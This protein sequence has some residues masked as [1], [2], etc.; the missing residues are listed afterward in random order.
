MGHPTGGYRR[1]PRPAA[2]AL[3][4]LAVAAIL[5]AGVGSGGARSPA[6]SVVT[7]PS[8]SCHGL[9][10]PAKLPQNLPAAPDPALLAILEV[11]RRPQVPADVPP[12]SRFPDPFL[13]G[14]EVGYERLL[15]TTARGD[16]YYLIPA[17]LVPPSPRAHC[18]PPRS[19][20]QQHLE[21]QLRLHPRFE[22]LISQIGRTASGGGGGGPSTAAA[23]TAGTATGGSF[24][25]GGQLGGYQTESGTIDSLVPDG[26]ASVTLKY[27]WRADR[28]LPVT[29]NFFL[30]TVHARI[31]LPKA[32]HPAPG[33]PV[34]STLAPPSPSESGPL[35]PIAPIEIVWRDAQGAAIK[36]IRQPAYCAAQHGAAQRTCLRALA[37]LR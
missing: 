32:P 14:I 37:K 31:K 35:G 23:I 26:V 34:P 28:T 6:T 25:I 2:A 5:A 12:A 22:L 7:V 21:H 27:R 18:S 3:L 19:P 30:L 36:T 1:P 13:Q 17:F 9:P 29:N 20:Q 4:G 10:V 16:R 24:G 15:T 8:A 33:L 11:L